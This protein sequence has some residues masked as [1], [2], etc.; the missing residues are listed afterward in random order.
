M[1]GRDRRGCVP[2]IKRLSLEISLPVITKLFSNSLYAEDELFSQGIGGGDFTFLAQDA[3]RTDGSLRDRNDAESQTFQTIEHLNTAL[4]TIGQQLENLVSLT[5]FL[6]DYKDLGVV[7]GSLERVF[8]D[9]GRIFPATTHIGVMGLD[10]G[11]RVRIDGV[12]TSSPSRE[13]IHAPD[14][15]YALG[16]RCHGVGIGDYLFLSGVDAED[17]H[18]EPSAPPGIEGQTLEALD[19]LERILRSQKLSLSDICRTFMFL[20]ST[21]HRPGY[22]EARKKRYQGTFSEDEFP[23]NSGIYVKELGEG[24]FLRSVA[25]AYRGN[26]KRMIHSP[27]VREAPGMFSQAVRAGNWVFIAGQDAIGFNREVEAE[28]DLAGQTNVALRHIKDIVE[29]AGGSLSDVIKTTVYLVPGQ[30]RKTFAAAYKN[31][32]AVHGVAPRMPAGLTVEVR[33]LAPACLVEIDAVALLQ[34]DRG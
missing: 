29:E 24:I 8:T 14:V 16:C 11:C 10:G 33:E 28:R 27:K 32:F 26:D 4:E 15:P 18:A 3:R 1:P 31:F 19:R 30:D 13:Q 21:A 9:P 5:F 25:I 17:P 12:A 6:T 20:P 23:P 7:A 22:G 2:G 34:N